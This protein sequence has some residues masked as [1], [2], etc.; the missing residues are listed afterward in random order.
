MQT[1]DARRKLKRLKRVYDSI[2]NVADETVK[3]F[4]FERFTI[5][6]D[7]DVKD[8][9]NRT[10]KSVRKRNAKQKEKRIVNDRCISTCPNRFRI[11]IWT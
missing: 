6:I 3:L 7:V 11:E 10:S 5:A 1:N 9:S 4:E 2:E 8:Q